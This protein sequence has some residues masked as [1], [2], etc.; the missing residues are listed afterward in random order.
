M[1]FAVFEVIDLRPTTP[2]MEIVDLLP[3]P[4]T[5]LLYFPGRRGERGPTGLASSLHELLQG[6]QDGSNLVFTSTSPITPSTEWVH[7]NGVPQT[8][9]AHYT[10]TDDNEITFT[11]P[12]APWWVLEIEYQPQLQ[13]E[14]P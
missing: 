5:E 4:T 3:P 1:T 14:D 12:P 10:V 9:P 7:V 2:R 13:P 11:Y 8:A 6:A